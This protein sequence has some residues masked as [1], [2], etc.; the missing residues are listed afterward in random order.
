MLLAGEDSIREVIAFPK[1]AQATCLMT[2]AP[3][4]VPE[5]QLLEAGVRSAVQT[6]KNDGPA[7]G[8]ITEVGS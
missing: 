4:G 1:T 2:G 6:G 3:T 8:Q 7:D 5:E